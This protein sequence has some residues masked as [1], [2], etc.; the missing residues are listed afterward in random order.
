MLV[1]GIDVKQEKFKQTEIHYYDDDSQS[2]AD[3]QAISAA[4][5][6]AAIAVRTRKVPRAVSDKLR[7]RAYGLWLGSDLP[8]GTT[9][10][11]PGPSSN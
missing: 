9:P 2:L 10:P 7:P 4:L 6:K 1:P 5:A 11:S 3:V 8:D